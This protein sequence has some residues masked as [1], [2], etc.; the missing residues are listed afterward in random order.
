MSQVHRL[1]ARLPYQR[2]QRVSIATGDLPSSEDV[3][4]LIDVHHLVPTAENGHPGPAEDQWVSHGERCQHPKMRRL[5]RSAPG[6][7]GGPPAD[8]LT[9]VPD[10]DPDV[11][12]LADCDRLRSTIGILL[13]DDAIASFGERGPGED[14]S[15]FSG[16]DRASG[17]VAGGYM[18]DYSKSDRTSLASP[19]DILPTCRVAVHG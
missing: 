15:A 6:D 8:V 4:C 2:H 18:L 16:P 5:E 1:A 13:A 3:F 7:H 17:K 10:V 12:I 9:G 11:A 19:S 14:S